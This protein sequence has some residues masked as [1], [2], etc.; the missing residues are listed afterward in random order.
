MHKPIL[1]LNNVSGLCWP[2]KQDIQEKLEYESVAYPFTIQEMMENAAKNRRE[3]QIKTL[4]RDRDIA[5]KF[6]KLAQ[7]NKE[8]DDKLSKKTADAQRAKVFIFFISI[9]IIGTRR[10]LCLALGHN[11]LIVICICSL[12]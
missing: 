5:A 6:A 12:W 11:R 9:C 2:S 3:E 1:L 4:E 7:W 8:L 10:S